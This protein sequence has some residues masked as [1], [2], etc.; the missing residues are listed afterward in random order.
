MKWYR[1]P[2]PY[3]TVVW[4]WGQYPHLRGPADWT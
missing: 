2:V 3:G 4:G 1:E